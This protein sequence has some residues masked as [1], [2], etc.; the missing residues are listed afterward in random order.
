M[1]PL[2]IMALLSAASA[3]ANYAGQK[4]VDKG[5]ANAMRESERRRKEAETRSAASAQ[6][7]TKLLTDAGRNQDAKA[8]EIEA[9]YNSHTPT[10]GPTSTGVGGFTAPP[11]STLTV[12]S[13]QR[14][15]GAV[16]AAAASQQKAK[17]GL[18]AYGDAM[19]SA[20]IGANRNLTDIEQQNTGVRN[21]QQYV[22]PAQMEAAN[23]SGKDWGTLADALQVAAAVYGPIGL[24]NSEAQIAAQKSGEIAK[25]ASLAGPHDLFDPYSWQ[26]W[27]RPQAP[28]RFAL[29]RPM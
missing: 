19:A 12:D 16:Q 13:D 14:A 3:G 4:K 20:Q 26:S 18:S 8:A 9:R 6:D 29:T 28:P 2:L 24:A 22:M 7:T 10:P 11:R 17:A 25:A 27:L 1:N 5:R 21:W 23:Q 15:M